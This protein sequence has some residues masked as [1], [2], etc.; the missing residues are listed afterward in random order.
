MPQCNSRAC[1]I[2]IY[3]A[4]HRGIALARLLE[5]GFPGV[6]IVGFFDDYDALRG[7]FI[8]KYK[9]VGC[10]R[11]L[12]TAHAVYNIHQIWLAFVPT[13]DKYPRIKN[14]CDENN[15]TLVALHEI[16]PFARLIVAAR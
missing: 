15:V 1:R 16:E 4:G 7:R 10:E 2:L 8:A 14:W 5:Q 3:G 13:D 6:Q 11:D 9:I 12:T